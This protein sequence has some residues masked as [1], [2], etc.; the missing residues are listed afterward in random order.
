MTFD[1]IVLE[2][3]ECGILISPWKEDIIDVGLREK[4]PITTDRAIEDIVMNCR[5]YAIRSHEY[6]ALLSP[7]IIAVKSKPNPDFDNKFFDDEPKDWSDFAW[8]PNKASI[9]KFTLEN[10]SSVVFKPTIETVSYIRLYK[11]NP[12]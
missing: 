12:I 11:M 6:N 1:Q 7:D 3:K 2:L 10:E 8:F 5:Y 9:G 4:E